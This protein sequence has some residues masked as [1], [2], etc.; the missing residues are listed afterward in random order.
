MRRMEALIAARTVVDGLRSVWQ[1]GCNML[2]LHDPKQTYEIFRLQ[3]MIA[4]GYGIPDLIKNLEDMIEEDQNESGVR[5]SLQS[6]FQDWEFGI[7]FD[8]V[9][10]PCYQEFLEHDY[11]LM[12]KSINT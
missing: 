12:L 9:I 10:W 3:W 4:H 6:L 1:R 5:T 7:G 2:D 8:C 11:P